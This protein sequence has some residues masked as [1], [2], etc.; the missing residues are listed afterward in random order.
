MV[1]TWF[2]ATDVQLFALLPIVYLV[3]RR[4]HRVLFFGL[5][6]LMS[7]A[8]VVCLFYYSRRDALQA[9]IMAFENYFQ[10]NDIIR[11]PHT[12]FCS[13]AGGVLTALFYFQVLKH[14]CI[15]ARAYFASSSELGF[16]LLSL[17]AVA[18]IFGPV[19]LPTSANDNLYKWTVNENALFFSLSRPVFI[20]GLICVFI[21]ILGGRFWF[22][23]FMCSTR[24]HLCMSRLIFVG[25]LF[26]PLLITLLDIT[27]GSVVVLDYL[28][29]MFSFWAHLI[30]SLILAF[31]VY[32]IIDGPLQA[33]RE[34]GGLYIARE[35]EQRRKSMREDS[36]KLT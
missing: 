13:L 5:L 3:Y 9:Q 1:W 24:L 34:I 25:Y 23:K 15:S 28:H 31:F 17:L 19:L 2:V 26:M 21:P 4:A 18:C 36:Q 6:A 8:S 29:I 33:F 35:M 30:F 14:R 10:F 12:H 32:L 22:T 27:N 7:I 11:H 16:A 20:A